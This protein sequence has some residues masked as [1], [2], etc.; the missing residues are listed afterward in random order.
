MVLFQ[1]ENLST[2]LPGELYV[3]LKR[4]LA[5]VKAQMPQWMTY[6]QYG[7]VMADDLFNAITGGSSNVLFLIQSNCIGN[8]QVLESYKLELF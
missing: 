7:G 6:G 2:V 4:H 3:R 1:G 8:L 5:Y